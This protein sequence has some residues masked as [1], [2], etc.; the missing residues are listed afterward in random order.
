METINK[1]EEQAQ[2]L[3][4]LIPQAFQDAFKIEM[5]Y[6]FDECNI[7]IKACSVSFLNCEKLKV[8]MEYSTSV[9]KCCML[10]SDS[11]HLFLYIFRD[12]T[13][14]YNWSIL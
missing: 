4:A 1:T 6:T 7:S 13:T 14:H 12:G 8:S 2:E 11:A 5:G 9:A 3:L 10:H